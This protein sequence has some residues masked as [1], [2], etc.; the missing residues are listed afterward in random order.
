MTQMD[1]QQIIRN[2]L[3]KSHGPITSTVDTSY[4][5]LQPWRF[6]RAGNYSGC[7]IV[8]QS[9]TDLGLHKRQFTIWELNV[10]CQPTCMTDDS[11][12]KIEDETDAINASESMISNL[13]QS[14]L[15]SA[16]TSMSML[17][18]RITRYPSALSP[19]AKT[20]RSN[21][22]HTDVLCSWDKTLARAEVD[23]ADLEGK[24]R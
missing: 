10:N 3:R 11:P 18:E 17:R 6:C 12:V 22:R 16:A 23:L 9:Q 24:V 21:P 2:R 19:I 4:E 13:P 7:G 8:G 15:T 1:W 5:K 14:K 20:D